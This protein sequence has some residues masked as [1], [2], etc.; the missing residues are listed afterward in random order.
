MVTV[1]AHPNPGEV[2][3]D[4]Q[5]R[6]VLI[7]LVAIT[8]ATIRY[9][10]GTTTDLPLPVLRSLYE[11]TSDERLISRALGTEAVYE[12]VS[13]NEDG[14][15]NVRVVDAPGLQPG[16][17]VRMTRDAVAGMGC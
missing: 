6:P 7:E 11:R 15:V 17:V 1:Q 2:W 10:D 9:V 5:Q 4:Q 3:V 13:D 8:Y 12:R 16:M 14:T